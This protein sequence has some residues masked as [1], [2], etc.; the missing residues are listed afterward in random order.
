MV[1]QTQFA[2]LAVWAQ[3]KTKRTPNQQMIDD[4]LGLACVWWGIER[5]DVDERV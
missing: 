5:D 2:R 4:P 3:K 1:E